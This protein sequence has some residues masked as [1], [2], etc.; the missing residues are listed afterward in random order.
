M[1]VGMDGPEVWAVWQAGSRPGWAG[2]QLRRRWEL[3][4]HSP[5]R[6]TLRFVDAGGSVTRSVSG[7][8]E[9]IAAAIGGAAVTGQARRRLLRA[10]ERPQ[11]LDL[12]LP[13]AISVN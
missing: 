9:E 3:I 13:L 4:Q 8:V 2:T 11:E 5:A 6:W 10:L 7:P 12:D 1:L